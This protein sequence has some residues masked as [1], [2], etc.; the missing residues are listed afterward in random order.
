MTLGGGVDL[1]REPR[2]GRNFEYAGEDRSLPVPSS[3]A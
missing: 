3:V 1:A 2:N